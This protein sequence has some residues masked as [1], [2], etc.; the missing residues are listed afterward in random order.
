MHFRRHMP[1]MVSVLFACLIIDPRGSLAGTQCVRATDVDGDGDI[2]VLLADGVYRGEGN[3]NVDFRGKAITVRSLNGPQ[4]TVVDC[5]FQ[6]RGFRFAGGEDDSS[7][8][9]GLTIRNGSVEGESGGGIA[10]LNAS[11]HIVN[12]ILTGARTNSYGGGGS[13]HAASPTLLNCVIADNAAV[14]GGGISCVG[15]SAPWI[16]N[17][18]VWDN[19]GADEITLDNPSDRLTVIASD[20]AT[21]TIGGSPPAIAGLTYQGII[22]G[23]P[24]FANAAS[25][26]YRLLDN[27]PSPCLGRAEPAYVPATDLDGIPRGEQPDIGAYENTSVSPVVPNAFPSVAITSPASLNSFPLS[28]GLRITAD[29]D[30]PDGTITRVEFFASGARV[31]EDPSA[32]YSCHWYPDLPGNYTLTAEAID[33]NGARSP[34]PAVFV[35]M[36][37]ADAT[38]VVD[39][40]PDNVGQ[41]WPNGYGTH[42]YVTDS[43]VFCYADLP[44]AVSDDVRYRATGW[45]GSGSVPAQGHTNHFELRIMEDSTLTWRWGKE[46]T[47]TQTSSVPGILN[48]RTWWGEGTA[49]SDPHDAGSVLHFEGARGQ[50][51][52]V[53][54]ITWQSAEDRLYVIESAA[55]PMGTYDVL[56]SNIVA[57]PPA[58]RYTDENSDA[59]GRFYRIRVRQMEGVP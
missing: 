10:C 1:K 36:I 22:N 29:A 55:D 44:E 28:R 54:E 48:T 47:L 59:A 20:L 40:S 41:C 50:A 3:V 18:I 13:C 42:A 37:V 25:G 43:V 49:G 38:L 23:T 8:L 57:T 15:G 6:G 53:F 2:D 21:D 30:D 45:T 9:N 11:P 33:N 12:C 7:V 16:A 32:P 51:G 17:S 34:S 58:N 14:F 39:G 26:N 19:P 4:H 31:G 56:A 52:G 24:L 35:A 5:E 27:P 46:F